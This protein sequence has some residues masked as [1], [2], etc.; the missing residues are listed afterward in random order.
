MVP[1][2]DTIE[3]CIVSCIVIRGMVKESVAMLLETIGD[4]CWVCSA[5]FCDVLNLPPAS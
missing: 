1:T 3:Q 4:L 5:R 2:Y